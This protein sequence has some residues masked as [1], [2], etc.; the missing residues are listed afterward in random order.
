M[1]AAKARKAG[2]VL[3]L[4]ADG[5]DEAE[6]PDDGLPFGLP[7]LLPDGAYVI[8]TY[9]TGRPPV[10]PDSPARTLRISKD[11]ERHRADIRAFLASE[12]GEEILAAR[13]ADAGADPAEFTR[14]LA[15]SCGGVWV[16]LR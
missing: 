1:A 8:G 16:Y 2:R 15:D 10:K 12:V 7:A 6:Q 3:V 11:D 9:R 14:Q 13:L 5:L 4:V